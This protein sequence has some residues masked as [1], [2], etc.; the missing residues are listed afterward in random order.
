MRSAGQSDATPAKAHPIDYGTP[1]YITPR[2]PIAPDSQTSV[3]HS[4]PFAVVIEPSTCRGSLVG[5]SRISWAHHSRLNSCLEATSTP[6]SS[7]LTAMTSSSP[8][9]FR[10]SGTSAV[11]FARQS[12]HSST[13]GTKAGFGR[14]LSW[15]AP[16]VRRTRPRTGE[17]R[18]YVCQ[19][20][21]STR[22]ASNT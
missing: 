9:D 17:D 10:R 22:E 8:A 4:S 1:A 21:T 14:D 2:C 20:I 16:S 6:I 18:T 19:R 11:T 12:Q 13:P 15:T 3:P 7:R 5:P